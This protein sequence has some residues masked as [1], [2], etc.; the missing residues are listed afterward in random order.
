MRPISEIGKKNLTRA[1]EWLEDWVNSGQNSDY[2]M[3]NKFT[4]PTSDEQDA[5]PDK[6]AAAES[7]QPLLTDQATTP[8][9]HVRTALAKAMAMEQHGQGE[10]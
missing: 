10:K 4:H 3:K 5:Q 7:S 2:L 6:P 9:Q 1:H 8:S